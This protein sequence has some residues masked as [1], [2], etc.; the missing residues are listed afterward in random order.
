MLETLVLYYVLLAISSFFKG[1]DL[2][3]T[4]WLAA[5]LTIFVIWCE[6]TGW[7]MDVRYFRI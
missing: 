2:E 1:R 6:L 7:H 4:L 3:E 5:V